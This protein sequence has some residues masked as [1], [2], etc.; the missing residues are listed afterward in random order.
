MAAATKARLISRNEFYSNYS[1]DKF[2]LLE[3]LISNGILQPFVNGDESWF[4]TSMKNA[5]DVIV[6]KNIPLEDLTEDLIVVDPISQ[7]P[8]IKRDG[9]RAYLRQR[10]TPVRLRRD[11]GVQE[12]ETPNNAV[13]EDIPNIEDIVSTPIRTLEQSQNTETVVTE[14]IE[15]ASATTVEN[16]VTNVQPSISGITDITEWLANVSCEELLQLTP[17]E[18]DIVNENSTNLFVNNTELGK[19]SL[20]RIRHLPEFE[21][22][23]PNNFRRLNRRETLCYLLI[24]IGAIS[25][26]GD[27]MSK[28]VDKGGVINVRINHGTFDEEAIATLNAKYLG[29]SAT[30]VEVVEEPEIAET[31]VENASTIDRG[32]ILQILNQLPTEV[33]NTLYEQIPEE[34]K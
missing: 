3:S 14:N 11:F 2:E 10:R 9:L 30:T 22:N 25:N 5:V 17:E 6:E 1:E 16:T 20:E 33:L 18:I 27:R 34:F 21:A 15:E 32:H 23:R 29:N 24:A 31:I 7:N 13:L 28:L 26:N 4:S 8:L 12:V 19:L